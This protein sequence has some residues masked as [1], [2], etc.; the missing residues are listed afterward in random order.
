MIT[1]KM[2]GSKFDEI[3]LFN[4]RTKSL[5]NYLN[6]LYE[7]R[8]IVKYESEQPGG[9]GVLEQ[10]EKKIIETEK[11][12]DSLGLNQLYGDIYTKGSLEDVELLETIVEDLGK[13]MNF[14]DSGIGSYKFVGKGKEYQFTIQEIYKALVES[15]SA[16]IDA[17][18]DKNSLRLLFDIS[19]KIDIGTT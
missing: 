13:Q 18:L 1:L 2:I 3:D 17:P 4:R 11:E 10:H 14:F 5:Q 8:G 15:D 16:L 12:I 7:D 6:D 9:V 19:K